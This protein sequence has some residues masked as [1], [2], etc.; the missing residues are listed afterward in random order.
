MRFATIV[1]AA[2]AAS[3]LA[4]FAAPAPA[5]EDNSVNAAQDCP[6]GGKI[7]CGTCN[8]TSCKIG[9]TNYALARVEVVTAPTA[10]T[11]TSVDLDTLFVPERL[12][13]DLFDAL[14]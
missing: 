9:F 7:N 14:S 2:L 5:P 6:S 4:A 10:G 11:T 12:K 13:L 8:G 1:F 3:P